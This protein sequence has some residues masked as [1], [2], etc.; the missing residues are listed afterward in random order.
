MVFPL[1]G[2]LPFLQPNLNWVQ[3]EQSNITSELD[4]LAWRHR[5]SRAEYDR[6]SALLS[7]IERQSDQPVSIIE[8]IVVPRVFFIH[9][10]DNP[11]Q[12]PRCLL[13]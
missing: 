1:E 10:L 3:E 9:V 12:I 5:R 2:F 8:R 7:E 4:T 11:F 13:P 6:I